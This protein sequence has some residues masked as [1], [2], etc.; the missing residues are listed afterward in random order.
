MFK[1]NVNLGKIVFTKELIT[2]IIVFLT[3]HLN[4]QLNSEVGYT[5]TYFKPDLTNAIIGRYNS[6]PDIL[7]EMKRLHYFGGFYLGLMYRI[8]IMK[9][10]GSWEGL[11]AKRVGIEGNLNANYAIEKKLYFY[12]NTFSANLEFQYG[13][14]GVGGTVDQNTYKLKT[15]ING[16]TSKIPVID[17]SGNSSKI[18]LIFYLRGSDKIGLSF[19]PYVRVPWHSISVEKMADYLNV[20]QN[21]AY[22]SEKFMQ[23]G[24]T[25]ALLNGLQPEF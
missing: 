20:Q 5:G 22:K 14:F 3:I 6:N 17:E 7:T 1:K 21:T 18:Y 8:G 4:A 16:T 15:I 19:K 12:F 2:I 11:S 23:F 13:H 10:G 24:I 25:I 9:I